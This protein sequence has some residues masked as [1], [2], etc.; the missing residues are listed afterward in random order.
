MIR[1][2]DAPKT[3]V[4]R[5][6]ECLVFFLLYLNFALP[7]VGDLPFVLLLSLPQGR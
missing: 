5:D 3:M 4:V 2:K 1:R 6:A 7:M